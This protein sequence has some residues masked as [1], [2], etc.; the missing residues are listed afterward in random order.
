MSPEKPW[1]RF[2]EWYYEIP[3]LGIA[4]DVSRMGMTETWWN[5]MREPMAMAMK[6]MEYI[7]A[8]DLANPDEQR[9]VGHYWLRDPG[10]A[11]GI[12]LAEIILSAQREIISFSRKKHIFKNIFNEK[13][14]QIFPIFYGIFVIIIMLSC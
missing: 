4:L 1:K 14:L 3:E 12:N 11:P 8:G 13:T 10:L 9:M 7:E 2:L 6:E 5:S